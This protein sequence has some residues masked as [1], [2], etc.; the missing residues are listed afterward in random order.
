MHTKPAADLNYNMDA[1]DW[2][3]SFMGH[4][5]GGER[6]NEIDESL[7]IAWFANAIMTGYDVGRSKF[8]KELGHADPAAF[9]AAVEELRDHYAKYGYPCDDKVQSLI[10]MLPK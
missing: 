1:L 5:G 9:R 6:W 3:K 7:M 8:R 4:F 2:A 10:A